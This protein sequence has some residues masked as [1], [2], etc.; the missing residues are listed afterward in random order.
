MNFQIYYWFSVT[1]SIKMLH[2]RI[3]FA[4]SLSGVL[5]KIHAFRRSKCLKN[6]MTFIETNLKTRG[7]HGSLGQKIFRLLLYRGGA[8][9]FP[10]G[11]HSCYEGA[12]IGFSGCYKFQKSPEGFSLSGRGLACSDRGSGPLAFP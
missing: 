9:N 11:A 7:F 8:R 4:L 6:F 2:S 5:L 12:K 10:T 1:A 3:H